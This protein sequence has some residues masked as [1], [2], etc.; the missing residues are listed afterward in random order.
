MARTIITKHFVH[1]ICH[2]L[3]DSVSNLSLDLKG[4]IYLE[5]QVDW[6]SFQLMA[7]LHLRHALTFLDNEV[8]DDMS[9]FFFVSGI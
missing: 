6:F 5:S 8:D 1:C 4:S 2:P 9:T 7:F 3:G